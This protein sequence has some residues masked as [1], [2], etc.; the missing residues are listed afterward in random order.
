MTNSPHPHNLTEMVFRALFSD[1]EFIVVSG[2]YV[3]VP[4][5]TPVLTGDSLGSIAQEIS[6]QPDLGE[7]LL[8]EDELPQRRP[9]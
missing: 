8:W 9:K 4:K 2:T 5:G 7:L 3:V 6:D 1:H